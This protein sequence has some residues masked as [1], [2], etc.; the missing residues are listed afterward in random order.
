MTDGFG[1]R[2]FLAGLA[3]ASAVAIA[4]CN[5]MPWDDESTSTAYPAQE[6]ATILTAEAPDPDPPAPIDPAPAA[7]ESALVRV[8]DLLEAV[9]DPLEAEHVP[10]GEIRESIDRTREDAR[11]ALAEYTTDGTLASIDP[12]DLSP[13]ERYHAFRA[14]VDARE[15]AREAAVAYAAIEDDSIDDDLRAERDDVVDLDA[16]LSALTYRGTDTDEGRLRAALVA[17]TAESDLERAARRVD[18]VSIDGAVTV[19]DL[20]EV[21]GRL[22][23]AAATDDVH[24]HLAERYEESLDEPTDLADVFERVVTDAVDYGDEL[25]LPDRDDDRWVDDLVEADLEDDRLL[26]WIVYDAVR[27]LYRARDD[28]AMA[29][30]DGRLGDGLE[31]ALRLETHRRA[32]D[33]VR[34]RAE[35]G[36]LGHP[37]AVADIRAER[38]SAIEGAEDALESITGPSPGAELLASTLEKLGWLDDRIERRLERSPDSNHSLGSEYREYVGLDAQ[39][40]VLPDA[41][42]AY[43]GSLFA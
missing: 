6:A 35:D 23:H 20:G 19:L 9:P 7:L 11:D 27:P 5:D 42:T 40:S 25:G 12:A 30:D 39:L 38:E 8:I 2:G 15:S 26:E 21:A 4:G 34:E 29:A 16:R 36:E 14:T 17:A 13:G 37:V 41:V 31:A 22:E 24:T 1:R 10:N 32:F 18:R 43:R 28:L 33:R 3:T